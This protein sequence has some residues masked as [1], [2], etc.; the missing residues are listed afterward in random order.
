ML[1]TAIRGL[2]HKMAD[3]WDR[4]ATI[5]AAS[6]ALAVMTQVGLHFYGKGQIETKVDTIIENQ[7]TVEHHIEGVENRI[8]G[9]Q[10]DRAEARR[11]ND[12]KHADTKGRVMVLEQ[13]AKSQNETL[14]ELKKGQE[15]GFDKLDR[16][17]D[18]IRDSMTQKKAAAN[19]G[20]DMLRR[21][22][23]LTGPK[24]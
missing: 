12:E 16:V 3:G 19:D 18:L 5:A 11:L 1:T 7:V 20:L 23:A 15:K 21:P 10:K 17:E 2:G 24:E 22:W 9:V 13:I 6:L 4:G 14:S 8:E